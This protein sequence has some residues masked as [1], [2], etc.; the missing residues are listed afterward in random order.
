M[1]S[2][3]PS[4][5]PNQLTPVCLELKKKGIFENIPALASYAGTNRE[6]RC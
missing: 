1:N 6:R 3:Q 4:S 2:I 5:D